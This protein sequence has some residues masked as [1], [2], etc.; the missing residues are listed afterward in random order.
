MPPHSVRDST[1]VRFRQGMS[2]SNAALAAST[3][4]P[5]RPRRRT[6]RYVHAATQPQIRLFGTA[7]AMMKRASSPHHRVEVPAADVERSSKSMR[8]IPR[9]FSKRPRAMGKDSPVSMAWNAARNSAIQ[10]AKWIAATT[11][12]ATTIRKLRDEW[13]IEGVLISPRHHQIQWSGPR[14]GWSPAPGS[15]DARRRGGALDGI[16]SRIGRAEQ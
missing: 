15:G 10:T 4:Y 8:G 16:V 13:R 1:T 3:S 6:H 7:S 12:A 14:S 5:L 2:R 11:P 9:T